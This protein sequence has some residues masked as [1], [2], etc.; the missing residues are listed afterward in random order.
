MTQQNQT[1]GR[2]A[3]VGAG[4]MGHGIALELARG[5]F[6]VAVYDSAPGRAD[7]AVEEARRDAH[8]LVAAG[9]LASDGIDAV[10]DRLTPVKDLEAA[11]A[12]A[13]FVA[14]AVAEDLALKREVFGAL[15][16]TCPPT[17]VLASNTSS[18][19]ISS[20]A[21]AC[22]HPE[23]VVL[24]HWVLPPHLIPAVEVAPGTATS[25]DTLNRKRELLASIGKWP[26]MVSQDLPGYLLNRLQ[27]ALLREA[28]HLVGSG[29]ATA[30]EIDRLVRGSLARRMPVLGLFRQADMAGLDV[31]QRIF[32]Y[33]G[34][35]LNVS[36]DQPEAL[37]EKVAAGHIGAATGRGMYT[38]EPG[39]LEAHTE[40]RNAELVR[41]LRADRSG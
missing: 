19:S 35:D 33:L 30:A 3:V 27:F 40:R 38:W 13:E 31:Y 7:A 12:D 2:A 36:P 5:G 6:D 10:I 4:R 20:I 41:L 14:E 22:R 39:E 9:V 21:E 11:G 17:A 29:V 37:V 32:E 18:I 16:R 1:R 24:A 15:D 28:L 26:I 8:D 23:R 34:A 25:P